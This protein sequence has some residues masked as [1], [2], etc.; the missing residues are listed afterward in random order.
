[1]NKKELWNKVNDE[2]ATM[3]FNMY[4]RWQDEKHYEDINDYLEVIKQ[5]IPQAFKISK[6]PFAITCKCDDGDI[7]ISVKRDGS[8]AKIFGEFYS[9]KG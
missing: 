9:K 7:K 5:K 8:Y 3:L 2:N 6:R 4:G 1:M